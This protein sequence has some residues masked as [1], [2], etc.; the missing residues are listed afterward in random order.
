MAGAIFRSA[1]HE[2]TGKKWERWVAE[3]QQIA[4]PD[5]THEEI[6]D[7]LTAD[8][9][10]SA[11]WSEITAVM[12]EWLLGRKPV[13]LTADVGFQIGVRRTLPFSL[14][15]AWDLLISKEGVGLWLGETASYRLQ[16]GLSLLAEDGT[17]AQLRVFKPVSH[18][19]MSW[20]RMEWDNPSA[21]QIRVLPV[22]GG[23]TTIS[24][25]QEKLEDPYIREIMR[26]HWEHVTDR[27]N[28]LADLRQEKERSH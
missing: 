11:E 15:E 7:Y 3:L 13:G 6:V 8:G 28:L 5:W 24:F 1:L 9:G 18:I 10:M 19:R 21:L 17:S 4:E 27:L 23:N 26:Q 20:Q 12:Y 22:S 2:H 14:E 16:A 25:H